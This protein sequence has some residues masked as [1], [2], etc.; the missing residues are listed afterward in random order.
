MKLPHGLIIGKTAKMPGDWKSQ[1]TINSII[2]GGP[3]STCDSSL[4]RIVVAIAIP[5]SEL[6]PNARYHWGKVARARKKQREEVCW[7]V[8]AEKNKI[9]MRFPWPGAFV[10]PH[11]FYKDKR[12]HADEDGICASLKAAR[13]GMQDAL[14]VENDKTISNLPPIIAIDKENPRMELW[15]TRKEID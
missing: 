5:P 9:G 3:K 7:L 11:V 4:Y 2:T 6:L 1:G 13:D 8:R 15:I 14:L 12:H 10:E